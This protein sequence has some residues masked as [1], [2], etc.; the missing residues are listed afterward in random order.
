MVCLTG[1]ETTAKLLLLG[2]MGKLDIDIP[3]S[4]L[5]NFEKLQCLRGVGI[6]RLGDY[7]QY[8]TKCQLHISGQYFTNA[9]LNAM[10][11]SKI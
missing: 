1:I 5:F 11:F 9:A 3:T 4:N 6:R 8:G 2:S 7:L 10:S